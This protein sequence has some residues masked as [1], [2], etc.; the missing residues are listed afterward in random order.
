MEDIE[1]VVKATLNFLGNASSQCTSLC[2]TGIPREYNK[3]LVSYGLE[4]N[5][6]FSSA[7]TTLLEPAFPFQRRQQQMQTL[8][9]FKATSSKTKQVFQK[10][11]PYQ[12]H[13][14]GKSY[15]LQRQHQP[16]SRG[17]RSHKS[18]ASHQSK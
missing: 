5:E 2:R 8:R 4:S 7:T 1:D 14:G 12:A 10:A 6:L 13:R 16:Y 18:Q 11:P 17:G 15:H 9:N 3:D